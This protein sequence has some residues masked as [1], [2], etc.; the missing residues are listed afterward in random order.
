M[1]KTGYSTNYY[2]VD[3]VSDKTDLS[4]TPFKIGNKRITLN[5]EL[6]YSAFWV[7][8]NLSIPYFEIIKLTSNKC[9]FIKI[10]LQ[11]FLA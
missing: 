7:R 4:I 11:L 5:S 6:D 1:F 9:Y 2:N 8:S 10:A 3:A